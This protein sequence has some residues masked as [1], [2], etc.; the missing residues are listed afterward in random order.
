MPDLPKYIIYLNQGRDAMATCDT[1]EEAFKLISQ[2][3]LIKGDSFVVRNNESRFR[4][5]SVYYYGE[6]K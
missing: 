5:F 1:L 2:R 3:K 4:V 6:D